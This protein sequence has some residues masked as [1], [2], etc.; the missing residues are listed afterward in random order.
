MGF[1]SVFKGLIGQVYSAATLLQRKEPLVAIEW[2]ARWVKVQVW[3]FR[4]RDI[5]VVPFRD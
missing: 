5:P 2:E 1:N 3:T 4:G